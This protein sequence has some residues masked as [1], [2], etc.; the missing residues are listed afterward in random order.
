MGIEIRKIQ[1]EDKQAFVELSLAL[2]KFNRR[3][4]DKHYAD[5]H[6]VLQIRKKRVEQRFEKLDAGS[7]IVVYMAFMDRQPAGYIRAFTYDNQLH[8]GCLD[9]L[10][11][12]EEAR[13]KNIGKKLINAMEQWMKDKGVVRLIVSVYSWNDQARKFYEEEGFCEYA[14]SFEKAIKQ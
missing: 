13:G 12:T 3:Q 11:L 7:S 1:K 6:N 5:F 9:E 10:Y 2:T 4:H 8:C 14:V